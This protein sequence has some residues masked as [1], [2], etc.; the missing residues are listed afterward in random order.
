MKVRTDFIT[1]SSSA[2][3]VIDL[4]YISAYQ[5]QKIYDHAEIAGDNAW[6][7]KTIEN[8]VQGRTWMDNF[9]MWNYLET[10]GVD[11]ARVEYDNED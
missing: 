3:F 2:S 11:M 8:Y 6:T 10:I 7:I 4:H 9:D 5:L 1:N